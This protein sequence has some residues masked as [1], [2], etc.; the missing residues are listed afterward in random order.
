MK[1]FRDIISETIRKQGDEYT[2]LSKKGKQLGKYDTK[3][4]AHKRLKQIE[5]FKRHR[6]Y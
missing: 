2:I 3:S 6:S 1:K 4:A 5:W